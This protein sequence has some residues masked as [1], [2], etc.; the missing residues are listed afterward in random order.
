R[1]RQAFRDL[2]HFVDRAVD[3]YVPLDE[4][5][6]ELA[7]IRRDEVIESRASRN[8]YSHRRLRRQVDAAAVPQLHAQGQRSHAADAAQLLLEAVLQEHR[9]H[10]RF[11]L[12]KV[13]YYLLDARLASGLHEETHEFVRRLSPGADAFF[14]R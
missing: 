10:G 4:S 2:E 7:Q 1:P 11:R 14:S 8:P 9:E 3:P 6:A 12:Q 5:L 13:R